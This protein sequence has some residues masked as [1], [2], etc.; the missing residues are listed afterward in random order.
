MTS[1]TTAIDR[2]DW[3]DLGEQLDREGYALLPRLLLPEHAR[4]AGREAGMSNALRRVTLAVDDA[5]R[6]ELFYFGDDL[7]APWR[8]W[9]IAFY[10]HLAV[11]ANRWSE[12]LDADRRYPAELDAFVRLNRQAGQTQPQSHLNRLLDGD[13]L[14]LHQRADGEQVFPF[15]VVALLTE[16]G[17]DFHGGEFVM[18][19]QRPRMQ[20]RPIVLPLTLGDAAII[21]TAQ[22]PVK[23]SAGYYRV[24]LKHAISRVR[25]GERIGVELSFH[26]AC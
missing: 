8:A 4:Q 13:Y 14:A 15:Q 11:I 12:S 10:R 22:R 23:G 20:S 18:T 5:G 24:N 3:A 17:R 25:G 6:G 7:P 21:S 26:D 19:E 16:P 2:L 9:R 1:S